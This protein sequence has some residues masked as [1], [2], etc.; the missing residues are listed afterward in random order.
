LFFFQFTTTKKLVWLE[1]V[2]SEKEKCDEWVQRFIE[3]A[4]KRDARHQER[5]E[6]VPT[7]FTLRKELLSMGEVANQVFQQFFGSCS[8]EEPERHSPDLLRVAQH[9]KNYCPGLAL[10]F[11]PSTWKDGTVFKRT[12]EGTAT[13]PQKRQR[14]DR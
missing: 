3:A 6:E 11:H 5:I 8:F 12:A 1:V 13:S 9:I 4:T 10:F 14:Q 2:V 7:A